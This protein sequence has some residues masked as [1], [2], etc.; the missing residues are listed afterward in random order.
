MNAQHQHTPEYRQYLE[1]ADWA[2]MRNRVLE[3]DKHL[4]QG[5][6]RE[7]ATQVHHLSYKNLRREFAFEL[8]SVC[9][10]CHERIHGPS[11]VMKDSSSKRILTALAKMEAAMKR[12]SSGN[13]NAADEDAA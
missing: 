11:P 1:S 12:R 6:L 10:T 4:C 7:R 8:I 2:T 13:D 9:D 5:C 3:R